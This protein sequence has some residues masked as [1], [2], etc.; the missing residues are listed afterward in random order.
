MMSEKQHILKKLLPEYVSLY[1]IELNSGKYEILRL[2]DNTNA[3][4]LA[5]KELRPF[6]TYDE[7]AKKYAETFILEDERKEFIDWHSC[8]NMKNRLMQEDKQTYHYHSVSKQGKD[9]YYEAY[10]VKEK[11][12]DNDFYILLGYRNIDSILYKEKAIQ[13]KLQRALEETKLSNEIISSIAK[14]YQYISRIDIQADTFEEIVNRDKKHLNF[15][16]TGILSTNNQKVCRQFVAEEYVDAFFKFTDITTLADR[17]KDEESI[18]LEYRMR[19]G[20]WHRMRFIEKKRDESGQ[21]THVLCVIRSISDAKKR[22]QE[23]LYQVAEAK[24]EAALKTRF[25]SNMSH[26]IRTPMNGIIGMLEL[27]NRYPNDLEVQQKCRDNIMESSK[28]LVSLVNNI[29]DINKLESGEITEKNITFDLAELLNRAN[30]GSQRQAADKKIEYVVDWTKA[31]L[32]YRYLI[33]NPLYLERMLTAVADNAIKFTN[34]GGSV[35]VWCAEK[36]SDAE[37][38]VYEFGCADTGIG[39]S[40]EFATH[41]FDLFSQENETSRSRYEGSGLGLA[42]AKKIADRLNGTIE[43]KSEK[44]VGTTALMTIPFRIGKAVRTEKKEKAKEKSL[45]GAC[46]LVAEDNELNMEIIKVILE[47]AGMQVDCAFDGM[48]AVEKFEQ[49]EPGCYQVICMDIMMPKLNG[50]DATRKIRSMRRADADS[51]PIIAMSANAF[52]EDIINSRISGMNRHLAK[53]LDS[54]RLLQTITECI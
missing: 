43:L 23:L 12:E 44:G 36:S 29:L 16:Q 24:K 1:R 53:P 47:D 28:H 26:D 9:S 6:T 32:R 51:I 14:T 17:M 20:N 41:A 25:L 49:S 4:Q 10:A 45:A 34:P 18:S 22:E 40:E 19:D 15:I 7:Y 50:W 8:K 35:H 11:V 13:E 39:M 52:A 54:A 27:A 5:D 21:L 30:T 37:H 3:R 33:G 38:V 48:E 46:V 31:E 2:A 42:I